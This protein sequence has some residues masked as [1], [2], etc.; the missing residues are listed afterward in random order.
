MTDDEKR[1]KVVF[2]RTGA[3]T[4]PVRDW[5]KSLSK[6]DRLAIGIDIKTVEFGWPIGMPTCRSLADGIWEVR[7][8]LRGRRIARTLFCI[9]DG[10]MVLLHAFVKKTRATPKQDLDVARRRKRRLEV[11]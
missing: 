7:S 1:L 9:D 8:N 3:K 11:K 10:Y 5:L 4:E 6:E 2:Y